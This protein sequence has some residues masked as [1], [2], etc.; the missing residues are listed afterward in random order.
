M[1]NVTLL[2]MLMQEIILDGP[3][4]FCAFAHGGK[5]VALETLGRNVLAGLPDSQ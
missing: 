2:L 4:L 5:I 1:E 3:G